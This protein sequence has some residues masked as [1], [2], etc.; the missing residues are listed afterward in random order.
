M[1]DPKILDSYLK[2]APSHVVDRAVLIA[3]TTK[4]CR[5]LLADAI[6]GEVKDIPAELAFEAALFACRDRSDSE[7]SENG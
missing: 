6:G 5:M 7:D 3:D 1:I 2:S 4:L